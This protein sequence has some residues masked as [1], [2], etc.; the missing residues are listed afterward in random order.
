[1]SAWYQWLVKI[2]M[3]QTYADGV[4]VIGLELGDVDLTNS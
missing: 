1:V 4:E 2:S 3:S